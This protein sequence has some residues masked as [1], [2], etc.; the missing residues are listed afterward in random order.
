MTDTE[1]QVVEAAPV[2][3]APVRGDD[4]KFAPKLSTYEQRQDTAIHKLF[5]ELAPKPTESEPVSTTTP[6]PV[7]AEKSKRTPAHEKAVKALELLGP[8]PDWI[9]KLSEQEA[10]EFA[11]H[12]IAVDN[13]IKAKVTRLNELEARYKADSEAS[14]AAAQHPV[15]TGQGQSFVDVAKPLAEKL[16]LSEDDLPALTTALE[17]VAQRATDAQKARLDAI[18][19]KL[20][21]RDTENEQVTTSEVIEQLAELYPELK[22][23]ARQ[24]AIVK[25]VEAYA[26]S[27]FYNDAAPTYKGR[28]EALWKDSL[29]AEFGDRTPKPLRPTARSNGQLMTETVTSTAPAMTRDQQIMANALKAAQSVG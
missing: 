25:R 24:T 5:P 20:T 8:K 26:K 16:G 22:D 28:V 6:A 2:R 7:E 13:E 23:E 15:S 19:A 14:T 10:L 21:S 18:E 11:T 29:R 12:R 9:G 1:T 27:G 4:G 17:T 3:E